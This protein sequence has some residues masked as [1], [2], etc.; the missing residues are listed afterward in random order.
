MLLSPSLLCLLH[1]RPRNPRN[2]ILRQG[3]DFNQGASR[4]RRW[5]ARTSSYYL[6]GVWM[7][8]HFIDQGERSNEELKSK[9]RIEREMQGEVKRKGLQSC[10]TSPKDVQPL[11]GVCYLLYSQVGRD[12][13]SLHELNKSTL[14]YSQVEGQGPPG[15]PL[16]MSGTPLQYL[17]GKSHGWRSLVGCSPWDR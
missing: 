12:K 5:R 4:L 16:H 11:E 6:I 2:K 17:P 1:N 10:K 15:K 9:F 7:P 14:V 13:L 8:G 3:R